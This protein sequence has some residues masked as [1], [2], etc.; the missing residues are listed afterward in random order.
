ME[1]LVKLYKKE[2]SDA[3]NSISNSSILDFVNLIIKAY[4]SE[5]KIFACG[6][7]VM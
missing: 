3:F 6:N 4:K 2:S 5:S 7:G 1:D